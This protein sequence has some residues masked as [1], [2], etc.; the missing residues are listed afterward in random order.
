MREPLKDRVRLQYIIE[1]ISNIFIFT[2]DKSPFDLN[3]DKMMFYAVVKNL[4]IIGE[5][6]YR[7]TKAFRKEHDDTE[8]NDIVRLRN[9]LVHDYYQVNIQTVWDIINNDLKPLQQNVSHYLEATDWKEWEK[10]ETAVVESAVHKSL[11]QTATRMKSR[12]YGI[13]EIC[14]I[15]G[16]SKGEIE[17]I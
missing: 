9:V 15:T 12:G 4:E 13:D 2:K 8:W 6:A 10:N 14:K 3:E 16:L 5:A 11:M 7:L 1:A 17:E